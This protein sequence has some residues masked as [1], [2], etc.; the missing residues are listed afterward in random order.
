MPFKMFYYIAG[1]RYALSGGRVFYQAEHDNPDHRLSW[2]R[3]MCT[4][5]EVYNMVSDGTV[6]AVR[7]F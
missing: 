3:S 4:Q 7:N 5:R 6:T 1:S 2:F